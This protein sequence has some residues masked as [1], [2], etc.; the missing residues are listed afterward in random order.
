[1][2]D[3]ASRASKASRREKRSSVESLSLKEEKADLSL[4]SG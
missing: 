4:R 2:V 1:M 3:A